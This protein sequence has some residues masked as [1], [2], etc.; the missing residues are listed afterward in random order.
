MTGVVKVLFRIFEAIAARSPEEGGRLIFQ[1]AAAGTESHGL[2]FRTGKIQPY[3]P[4]ALDEEKR[5]Y[6]WKVLCMRLD[7]LQPG[8]LAIVSG[9]TA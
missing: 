3:A 8:I 2:Y 5:M 6:V 9:S 7:K 1:A 4:I